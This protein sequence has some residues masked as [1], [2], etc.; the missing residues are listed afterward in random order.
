MKIRIPAKLISET[1]K[2][3]GNY[4]HTTTDM[5][6]FLNFCLYSETILRL[7]AFAIKSS[8][9]GNIYVIKYKKC[10]KKI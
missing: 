5:P 9:K 7:T 4:R 2:F 10:F 8:E 3:F 1:D 6:Y